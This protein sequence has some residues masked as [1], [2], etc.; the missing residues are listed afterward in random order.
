MSVSQSP[1]QL[2]AGLARL[3]RLADLTDT[4]FR[5]PIIGIRIGL[6]AIIGLIPVIGD[7]IGALIS[8][9]LFFEAVRLGAPWSLRVRMLLNI[10]IDFVV[11]LI[12]LLGDF[13]DV[14]FKANTRN[15][16][17]LRRW[18]NQKTNPPAPQSLFG[19][20]VTTAAAGL[21]VVALCGWAT[22][23]LLIYVGWL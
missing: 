4:R 2:Q 14:A 7:G 20:S 1:E 21:A 3:E 5:V 12:P 19:S 15:T 17:L 16:A 9:Y 22:H 6:E 11:G 18:I 13:A 8:L 10:G 23:V